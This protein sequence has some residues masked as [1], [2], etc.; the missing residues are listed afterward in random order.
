MAS[1]DSS[2]GMVACNYVG[3]IVVLVSNHKTW[4]H[5]RSTLMRVNIICCSQTCPF[6]PR[7]N[8]FQWTKYTF[9]KMEPKVSMWDS[10]WNYSKW[11]WRQWNSV[12]IDKLGQFSIIVTQYKLT[13]YGRESGSLAFFLP[14]WII[15]SQGSYSRTSRWNSHTF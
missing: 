15:C 14:P 10:K 11:S 4:I 5:L 7:G 9:S 13:E 6:I 3:L 12:E 2:A 1:P 8:L